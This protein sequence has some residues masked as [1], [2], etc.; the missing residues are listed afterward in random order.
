MSTSLLQQPSRKKKIKKNPCEAVRYAQSDLGKH[1]PT[2]PARV[3]RLIPAKQ[4]SRV[5][6]NQ[7]TGR[8]PRAGRSVPRP[9]R[10]LAHA[11]VPF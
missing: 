1:Y 5:L 9:R 7:A 4:V 10:A 11:L 8:A 6:A 3:E 2:V